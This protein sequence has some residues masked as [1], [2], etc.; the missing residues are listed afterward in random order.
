MADK[1]HEGLKWAMRTGYGARGLIYVV[2]GGIAFW[3]ALQSG[4]AQGTKSALA[5]LRDEPFGMFLLWVIGLGLFGYL[6]WRVI[7]G[8]MDLE[9]H[10]TDAKGIVARIGQ[11]TTGLIHGAIGVT[12]ISMAMGGSSGGEGGGGGGA[13]SMTARVLQ[14]EGGRWIVTIGGLILLGAG[15]YYAY[16]GWSG[17]YRE[18]LQANSFTTEADKVLKG[19]LVIYGILLGI[20]AFSIIYA[21]WTAN[22]D[23]AGGLGEALRSVREMTGGRILL[24][25]AGLGLLAFALYNFV[26]AMY[27]VVPKVTG[28][29]MTT[30]AKKLA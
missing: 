21:G 19:G 12:V 3:A 17:K 20:T 9:D 16:K 4:Q 27:R 11:V 14:M 30:L 13:E 23:Q 22:P 10:G 29:D 5:S 2:V 18:H 15:V 28:T 26:E 24:G 6:I 1:S 8:S 7:C 25:I